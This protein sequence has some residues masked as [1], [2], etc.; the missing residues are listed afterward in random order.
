M[1]IHANRHAGSGVQWMVLGWV[2][3]A[4]AASGVGY[5]IADQLVSAGRID[6]TDRM[7]WTAI[8]ATPLIIIGL[9]AA[10]VVRVR[11][12]R[13]GRGVT[14]DLGPVITITKHSGAIV[15]SAPVHQIDVTQFSLLSPR[16]VEGGGATAPILELRAGRRAVTIGSTDGLLRWRSS[17][18]TRYTF[19]WE[20]DRVAFAAI[21]ELFGLRAEI[22]P[23]G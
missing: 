14:I 16:A 6:A 11:S 8:I 7:P 2:V 13:S 18:P 20:C 17:H 3:A 19:D 10:V 4:I 22:V 9:V 12:L 23:M 1:R 21:A 15:L 5:L